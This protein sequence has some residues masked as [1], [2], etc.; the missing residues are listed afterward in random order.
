M[1]FSIEFT[2]WVSYSQQLIQTKLRDLMFF[3][4]NGALASAII[5]MTNT[6]GMQKDGK[7]EITKK[8]TH[9]EIACLIGTPRETVTR[10]LSQL[11]KDGL[12]Q[13][14]KGYINVIDLAGLRSICRCEDC[15]LHVCR[16]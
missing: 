8:I 3:G 12:I 10:M 11:K 2:K 5:R 4:K 16:L 6:Y 14:E 7:W 9:D 13:N 1:I 15:P